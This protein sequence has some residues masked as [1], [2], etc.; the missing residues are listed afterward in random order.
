MILA[1]LK[2]KKTTSGDGKPFIDLV[3]PGEVRQLVF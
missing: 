2:E 1:C 3:V